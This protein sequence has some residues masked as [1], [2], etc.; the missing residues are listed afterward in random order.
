ML[1]GMQY[2]SVFQPWLPGVPPKQTEFALD[3]ICN[4]SSM[5]L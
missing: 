3:Q 4:H 2:I 5:W 1:G